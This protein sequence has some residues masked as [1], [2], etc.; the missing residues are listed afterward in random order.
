MASERAQVV[1]SWLATAWAWFKRWVEGKGALGTP[2]RVIDR[3]RTRTVSIF[4]AAIVVILFLGSMNLPS[5]WV[6][7]VTGW[8]VVGTIRTMLAAFLV[9]AI[10]QRF[11]ILRRAGIAA[12]MFAVAWFFL[13]IEM[14]PA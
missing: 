8:L 11:G 9:A 7:G 2:D 5:A 4:L 10:L 1:A 6:N 3:A 14:R 13:W 12:A